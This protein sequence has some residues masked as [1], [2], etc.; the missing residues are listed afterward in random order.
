MTPYYGQKIENATICKRQNPQA[1][2]Q[3]LLI[4]M[5]SA[6]LVAGFLYAIYQHAE[7]VKDGYKTQ[8]LMHLREQLE[9]EKHRLELERAYYRSPQV[10]EPLARRLGLVRPDSSQVIVTDANGELK[11]WMPEPK[12]KAAVEKVA[13]VRGESGMAGAPSSATPSPP[14]KVG[15]G[16]ESRERVKMDVTASA[17][18][19]R[20]RRIETAEANAPTRISEADAEATVQADETPKPL[21]LGVLEFP[22]GKAELKL[23]KTKKRNKRER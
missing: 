13:R 4:V 3:I 14:P 9:R 6:L 22:A 20:P 18:R 1:I 15:I 12:E 10:I 2:Q 21:L 23:E 16:T 17:V 19:T 7:A 11:R 5:A 8:Q